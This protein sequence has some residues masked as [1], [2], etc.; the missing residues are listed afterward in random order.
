MAPV[1][2]QHGHG[3]AGVARG[4]RSQGPRENDEDGAEELAP[5]H[6]RGGTLTA[7]ESAT[8]ETPAPNPETVGGQRNSV[9]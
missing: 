4:G 2:K 3:V 8:P 6:K 7:E 9:P 1:L 5:S